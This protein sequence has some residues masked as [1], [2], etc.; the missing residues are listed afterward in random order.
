MNNL[1]TWA[2]IAV[3]A[4]VTALLRFL[5]FLMFSDSE[6]TPRI[7][8]KLNKTLPFAVMGML[9]VYCFKDINFL[10]YTSFLPALIAGALVVGLYLWKRNTLIS[11]ASG[12]VCYML[13][14]QLIF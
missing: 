7:I 14:V 4:L 13:L 1:H 9:V 12:T 11:I 5:P 3:S 10:S 6:K 8:K 2:I